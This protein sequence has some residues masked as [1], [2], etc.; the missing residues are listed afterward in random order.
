MKIYFRNKKLK[1]DILNEKNLRKEYGPEMARLIKLRITQLES[2]SFLD[3]IRNL[4][5]VRCHELNRPLKGVFSVDLVHPQ[6]FLFISVL[7]DGKKDISG[8]LKNADGG[9]D[10]QKI[11]AIEVVGIGDTHDPKCVKRFKG[12]L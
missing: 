7:I 8:E 3:E 4:P 11:T 2:A 5:R 9:L 6:R 10:W 12:V 1:K